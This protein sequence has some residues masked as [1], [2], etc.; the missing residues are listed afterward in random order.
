VPAPDPHAGPQLASATAGNTSPARAHRRLGEHLHDVEERLHHVA[1]TSTDPRL[2]TVAVRDRAN[3]LSEDADRQLDRADEL[4]PG[5]AAPRT[6][7]SVR[8]GTGWT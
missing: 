7:S 8:L 6:G 3:A 4:A 2:D 5:C 1:D